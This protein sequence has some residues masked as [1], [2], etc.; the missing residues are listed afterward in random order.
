MNSF[1]EFLLMGGYGLYVWTSYGITFLV[2]IYIGVAPLLGRK[3]FLREL[4]DKQ[5]RAGK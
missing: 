4:A 1:E 2:L 5:K 3:N